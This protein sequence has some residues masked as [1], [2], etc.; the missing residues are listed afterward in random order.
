MSKIDEL[1]S[2]LDEL[3][4]SDKRNKLETLFNETIPDDT[5]IYNVND[6]DYFPGQMVGK[7]IAVSIYKNG[8][9]ILYGVKFKKEEGR[10]YCIQ[11]MDEYSGEIYDCR[12]FHVSYDTENF[13]ALW[14]IAI[15]YQKGWHYKEGANEVELNNPNYVRDLCSIIDFFDDLSNREQLT[16]EEIDSVNEILNSVLPKDDITFKKGNFIEFG[17]IDDEEAE[18]EILTVTK[19]IWK[20][21][22]LHCIERLTPESDYTT[23]EECD[24]EIEIVPTNMNGFTF[25]IDSL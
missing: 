1:I 10:L 5:I 21:G 12:D 20:N 3:L 14:E 18:D 22:K 6:C 7:S 25:L 24:I 9:Q 4:D 13:A 19:A 17:D 16:K 15:A 11:T 23:L 2:Y 8:P